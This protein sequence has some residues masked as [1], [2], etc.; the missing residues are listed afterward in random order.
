VDAAGPVLREGP[1]WSGDD[2]YL[3]NGVPAP[4]D[5]HDAELLA[6]GDDL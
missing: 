2:P 3:S 4:P 6:D 1:Y 5:D